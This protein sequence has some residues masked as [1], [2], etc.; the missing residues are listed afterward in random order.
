MANTQ[1]KE[2]MIPVWVT[3]ERGTWLLGVAKNQEEVDR[4]I[5]EY[6]EDADYP[7]YSYVY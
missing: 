5:R 1:K 3:D 6:R 2:T 4:I 7:D